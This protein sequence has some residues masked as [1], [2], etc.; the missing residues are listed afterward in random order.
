MAHTPEAAQLMM[1]AWRKSGKKF[2]IGYQNRFRKEVTALHEACA[3][4]DLGKFI[5]QKPMPFD[6]KLF[7]HGVFSQ[8][9]H[10]KVGAH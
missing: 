6:G 3:N 5:L 7:Q 10:N 1:D 2:T 9:N 4:G 8:I